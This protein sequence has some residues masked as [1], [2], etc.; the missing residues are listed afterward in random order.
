VRRNY[1]ATGDEMST[2]AAVKVVNNTTSVF[3]DCDFIENIGEPT[4]SGNEIVH[5]TSCH[6]RLPQG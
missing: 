1:F 6:F 2:E 3:A 4:V 5:F